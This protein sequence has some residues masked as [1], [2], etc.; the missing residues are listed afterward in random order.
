MNNI[1]KIN[2]IGHTFMYAAKRQMKEEWVISLAACIGLTQGLKYNGSIK[3]GVIGAAATL[4]VIGMA[5]GVH[6]VISYWD[7]IKTL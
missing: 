2:F 6:N 7:R 5:N 4:G 3:R 1:E